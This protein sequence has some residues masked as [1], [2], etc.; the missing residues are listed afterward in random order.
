MAAPNDRPG[1]TLA[2]TAER[3][4]DAASGAAT[5]M[6]HAADAKRKE[7]ATVLD[8]A[9]HAIGDQAKRLP[10]ALGEYADTAK[11]GITDAADYVRH[12]D[13]KDMMDDAVGT[14]KAHP[15]TSI[16]VLGAVVVGGG[17]L[18]ANAMGKDSQS[19]ESNGESLFAKLSNGWGPEITDKV[20]HFRD[21]LFNFAIT[22]VVDNLE[23]IVPGFR[24]HFDKAAQPE[25]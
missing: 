24:D 22:G 11:E 4:H 16:L 18:L 23:Q 17:L 8:R 7:G 15:I 1:P 19:G 3:A 13:A 14:A 6:E 21:S 9:A 20:T 5:K 2:K 10:G 12:T 25:S